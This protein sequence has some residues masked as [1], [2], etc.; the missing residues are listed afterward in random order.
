MRSSISSGAREAIAAIDEVC[1]VFAR[2][3]PA[4][5]VRAFEADLRALA[6]A[7]Q[8]AGDSGAHTLFFRLAN[9]LV[10]GRPELFGH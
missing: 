9:S 2:H 1:A 7:R 3:L 8:R 6:G 5:S 10:R 4:H